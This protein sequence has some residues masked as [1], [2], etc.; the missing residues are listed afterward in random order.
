LDELRPLERHAAMRRY[1]LLPAV[2][3]QMLAE[4]GRMTEAEEA[5]RA[6]LDCDCSEP[7]RR[8]LL[9]RLHAVIAESQSV[10][11]TFEERV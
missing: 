1:H 8:F 2:R 5:F 7:E 6:A 3:G 10:L 11:E 4:L 9:K